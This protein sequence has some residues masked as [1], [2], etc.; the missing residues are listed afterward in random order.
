MIISVFAGA[1]LNSCPLDKLLNTALAISN[2]VN[3]ANLG[4]RFD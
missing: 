4:L 1:F 3:L 2:A